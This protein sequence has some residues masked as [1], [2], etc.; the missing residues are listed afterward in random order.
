VTN[1]FSRLDSFSEFFKLLEVNIVNLNNSVIFECNVLFLFFRRVRVGNRQESGQTSVRESHT[2]EANVT[3]VKHVRRK[4][5]NDS[6][7][8]VEHVAEDD[9]KVKIHV[10]N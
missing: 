2:S 4:A 6:D 9:Q 3:T 8:S 10:T 5:S 1:I 7:S